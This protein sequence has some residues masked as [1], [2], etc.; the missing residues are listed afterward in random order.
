MN[1]GRTWL[2]VFAGCYSLACAM[3][4]ATVLTQPAYGD[5]T[6]LGRLS[7]QA[8]GWHAGQ[9]AID[10]AVLRSSSFEDADI[11]VIGDSFSTDEGRRSGGVQL[12]WQSRLVQAGY[13]VATLHVNE[14]DPLCSGL[15]SWLAD[16]GFHGHTVVVESVER[17]LDSLLQRSLACAARKRR[18]V[19][20]DY[21]PP[22]PMFAAPT[23]AFNWTRP[24]ATGTMTA[25]NTARAQREAPA[26]IAPSSGT[27]DAV[28]VQLVEG[29][30]KLFSHKT[31]DRAL[32]LAQDTI[33]PVLDKTA[34]ERMAKIS[35]SQPELRIVW[36]V[37]P[38]KSSVYLSSDRST[39]AAQLIAH[40]GLGPDLFGALR[41]QRLRQV[42]LYWPNDTHLSPAGS[43]FMGQQIAQWL[44]RP[45]AN[46]AGN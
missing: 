36:V 6:R 10:P 3:L 40:L 44:S 7:E 15:S 18:P 14:V 30:C 19:K 8:F 24:I 42:D 5:L 32:F 20:T 31:C 41:A 2:W 35:A 16:Q 17:V 27:G 34:V 12:V 22:P 4:C 29:G 23:F 37:V 39:E 21:S 38:N 13:R 1:A 33:N 43:L 28:R 25:W 45:N 46:V 26:L 11:V 9:P